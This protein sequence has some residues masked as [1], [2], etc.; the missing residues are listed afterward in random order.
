MNKKGF[1]VQSIARRRRSRNT[2]YVALF[3][4]GFLL[5]C[6]VGMMSLSQAP[7][8]RPAPRHTM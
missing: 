5:A 3:Y 7:T 1:L 2:L 4:V 8:A 6:L